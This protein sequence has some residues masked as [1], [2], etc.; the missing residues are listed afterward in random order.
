[1][2]PWATARKW[3]LPIA[4]LTLPV[5]LAGCTSDLSGNPPSPA[6]KTSVAPRLVRVTRPQSV[7]DSLSFPS[8]LYIERDVRVAARRSGVIEQVLVDRG[9]SVH[10]GQPLAILERDSAAAELEI[11]RQDLLLAETEL[12]RIQ[13]L[14]EQK[15]ASISDFDRARIARDRAQGRLALAE[16][17]LE[18]CTV[19]APFA[20]EVV[21][22]WAVAGMRVQEDDSTPLFRVVARDSL[23][24]RVDLPEQEL[25]ALKVG[26]QA[27]VD[28]QDEDGRAVP[29]KVVFISPAIDAASGTIPIIVEVSPGEGRVR[30]GS[31]VKVR[32]NPPA[33]DS[34]PLMKLP[35]E[36]L[37][38]AA[39]PG[40]GAA[41][42]MVVAQGQASSRKV[43]VVETRGGS[44]LLRGPLGPSDRVI[45]GAGSGLAEGDPVQAQEENP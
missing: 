4:V 41:E 20:G 18:Y 2:V 40:E 28:M 39:H 37:V 12:Q 31:A 45:V 23:R 22:R 8:S 30:A 7:G 29:A 35:R 5:T 32:F 17:S 6:V 27:W 14:Y 26:A 16:S 13:P 38:G 21:E 36:A 44:I 10:A 9:A 1:V 43:L 33:E 24:A 15:I 3:I 11:A 25:R 19:R 42:V 34:S